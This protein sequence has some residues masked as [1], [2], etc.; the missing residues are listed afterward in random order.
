M[1]MKIS[2]SLISIE[3]LYI[4]ISA[5]MIRLVATNNLKVLYNVTLS[6]QTLNIDLVELLWTLN[7]DLDRYYA[8]QF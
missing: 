1:Q 5:Y 3:K 8:Y 2:T 6:L 4:Q 7:I